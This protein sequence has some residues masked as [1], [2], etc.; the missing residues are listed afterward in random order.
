MRL[1]QRFLSAVLL[2]RPKSVVNLPP[3]TVEEVE[4]DFAGSR[5][6]II[7]IYYWLRSG[8]SSESSQIIRAFISCITLSELDDNQ[9]ANFASFYCD[10][11]RNSHP[12]DNGSR[13]ESGLESD[14]AEL[15]N[16]DDSAVGIEEDESTDNEELKQPD[17]D[18]LDWINYEEKGF[19]YHDE[20][21]DETYNPDLDEP[22]WQHRR[23]EGTQTATA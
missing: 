4:V 9:I 21:I 23:E 7:I 5:A 2:A 20:D 12:A 14:D 19:R 16:V 10:K 1:L 17:L 3:V 11:M 18:A 22:D 15:S 13:Q 6:E 8:I